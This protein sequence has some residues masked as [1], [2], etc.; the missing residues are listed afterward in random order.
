LKQGIDAAFLSPPSSGD[1]AGVLYA[2]TG[3]RSTW[4]NTDW[5]IFRRW[6]FLEHASLRKPW[7]EGGAYHHPTFCPWDPADKRI[8][9]AVPGIESLH[10]TWGLN[11]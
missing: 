9:S 8:D 7:M 4:S 2:V 6:I 5:S 3:L 10:R 11:P 1:E